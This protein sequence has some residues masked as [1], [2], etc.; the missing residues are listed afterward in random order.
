VAKMDCARLRFPKLDVV[1]SN[2]IARF[3]FNS[4]IFNGMSFRFVLLVMTC[5]P[6]AGGLSLQVLGILVVDFPVVLLSFG[7][8]AAMLGS[9]R[10]VVPQEQDEIRAGRRV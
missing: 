10:E 3:L 5:P 8:W 4:L 6:L 7:Q 1:G 2:P 9:R